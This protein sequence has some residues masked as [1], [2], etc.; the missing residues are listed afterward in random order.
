M[1]RHVDA[2]GPNRLTQRE[3]EQRAAAIHCPEY[4]I[5]LSLHAGVADYAGEVTIHFEHT[6]PAAGTFLDF[7]GREIGSLEINGHEVDEAA[8]I[9][10][11]LF[12]DGTQLRQHNIVRIVYRND[13]NHAGAGLHYFVDPEDGNEYLYTQ[14]EPYEAH[15]LFPCFDQPDI[16]AIYGLQVV[17]PAHWSVVTNSPLISSEPSD[18]ARVTRAFATTAAFSTYLFALAA[19]PFRRFEERYGEIPL[20]LYCRDSLARYIDPDELFAITKQGLEFFAAFFDFPYP[21]GKYDQLFCP[22]FNFGAM[23]NV[24]AVMFSEQMIF[25]D[26][27]TELQRLERAS[28]ILHEM[29][30]MWFGNLVTMRWWNDLWLNE[31]FATYMSYLAMERVT[32]FRS[33][34][35]LAFHSNMKAWAYAQDQLVTTHPITGEVPDTDATFLNFDGITYGKGASVLK[36]LVAAIGPEGFQAGMRHYFKQYAWGN[37]TLSEFLDAL[38]QATGRDLTEWSKLWLETESLNTLTPVWGTDGDT[39]TDIRIEQSAPDD[40]PTLRPHRIDL[41][42]FDEGSTGNPILREAIALDVEGAST[43]VE[44][45]VGVAAPAA[46]LPNYNDH[47][48]AK[49]ILD[50]C[51]LDFVCDRLEQFDDSFVRL[52]LW[53]ILWDMV[54]DQKLRSQEYLALVLNKLPSETHLELVNTVLANAQTAVSRYTPEPMRLSQAAKLFDLA[55]K[56][57]DATTNADFRITWVRALIGAAQAPDSLRH[58][59]KLVDEGSGIEGF[60]FDQDMRWALVVKANAY[61]MPDAAARLEAELQRDGSDRGQRA[62]ET[63][64]TARPDATLKAAAWERFHEDRHASMHLLRAA[65][66]GFF[67]THQQALLEPYI[68]RYFEQVRSIFQDRD[69]DFALAY[70]H[71]LYPFHWPTEEVVVRNQALIDVLDPDEVFLRRNLREAQNELQRTLAC[72]AYAES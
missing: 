66:H 57:L 41:A 44:T 72:R 50:E 21:F 71:A 30:H 70:F 42:L 27:P 4:T 2:T 10:N 19:G 56:S 40:Y 34:A 1:I 5:V 68:G 12:L 63:A 60:E 36:Q 37:T 55:R 26:L 7:T 13:Y 52:L 58:L 15:R 47:G 69:K 59:L 67:W 24:G 43:T 65:M 17:A 61:D 23:E 53:R 51:T 49:L 8:W 45:L 25:R 14:F 64:R 31:S 62:A 11:R 22:E 32:R 6:D 35:W 20:A 3:A 54:R 46:I 38:R 48:Y 16:K 29:A 28:T 39:I 18:D 33:G 9:S